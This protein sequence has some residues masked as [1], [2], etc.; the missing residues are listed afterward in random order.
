VPAEVP[1]ARKINWPLVD[2]HDLGALETE[3]GHQ[4]LLI[5]SEGID[6]A[7]QRAGGEAAGFWATSCCTA[8][9]QSLVKSSAD[10]VR[11]PSSAS[12]TNIK[13]VACRSVGMMCMVFSVLA[14]FYLL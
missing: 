8:R 11:A 5:E 3:A 13:P 6:T 14:F 9:R 12:A 7:V 1:I 2:P 10:A 4:T